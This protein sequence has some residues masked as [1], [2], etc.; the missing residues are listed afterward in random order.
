MESKSEKIFIDTDFLSCFLC[1]NETWIL[2]KMF[3]GYKIL[4]PENVT[5]EIFKSSTNRSKYMEKLQQR[6]YIGR[7]N[8][9]FAEANPIIW[10]TDEFGFFTKIN[11]F[12]IDG[13]KP[14]GVGEAEAITLCKFRDGVLASNNSKDVYDYVTHF[15]IEWITTT[16]ILY[17]AYKESYLTKEQIDRI[18]NEMVTLNRYL[19]GYSS[20][21]EFLEKKET[22]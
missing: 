5:K 17:K 14:I 8:G 21:D 4:V 20:F 6:Y 15:H 11:N 9:D 12:G 2:S 16:D 7:A 13:L 18:W 3:P 19:G 10:D 1:V 22:N